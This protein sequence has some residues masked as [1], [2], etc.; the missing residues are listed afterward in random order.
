VP[1][2]GLPPPPALRFRTG[3]TAAAAAAARPDEFEHP[4]YTLLPTP[5]SGR[6]LFAAPPPLQQ[7]QQHQ[8]QQQS[9]GL[10]LLGLQQAQ[11]QAQAGPRL[12]PPRPPS[13]APLSAGPLQ[14]AAG[15]AGAMGPNSR[16]VH[17]RWHET[18]TPSVAPAG[19]LGLTSGVTRLLQRDKVERLAM[20][21][22]QHV[23]RPYPGREDITELCEQTR[24]S[25]QQVS[26][27]FANARRRNKALLGLSDRQA[28]ALQTWFFAHRDQPYLTRD[29][30]AALH[31]ATGLDEAS[32]QRWL[33][34]A[35]A[36]LRSSA[37][38]ADA[39]AAAGA[40]AP[41]TPSRT[42]ADAAAA[43]AGAVAPA[44]P[45]A[46]V[47]VVLVAGAAPADA[48]AGGSEAGPE[49]AASAS[50]S[51][52]PADSASS[53]ATS[54]ASEDRPD[55]DGSAWLTTRDDAAAA[56]GKRGG[57][58]RAM[59]GQAIGTASAVPDDDASE[60]SVEKRRKVG[61]PD[62]DPATEDGQQ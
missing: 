8:Q 18:A 24:L 58:G 1:E 17:V 26:N 49:A 12:A 61:D 37:S 45:L 62:S 11:A 51:P 22:L 56:L 53:T 34:Q 14:L 30:S 33:A 21:F 48:A 50:A 10:D 29:D 42:A 20:W 3:P 27:W 6:G 15:A 31:D 59:E 60:V 16:Y 43:A 9:A 32:M 55:S 13:P 41:V 5:L 44:G 7:Q 35:R 54:V 2:R 28:A 36:F 4:A 40:A 25:S 23:A 57:D 47:P 19:T 38:R 52:G 46:Q 39:A